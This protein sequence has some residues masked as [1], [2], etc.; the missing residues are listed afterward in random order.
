M[1][2]ATERVHGWKQRFDVDGFVSFGRI[3]DDARLR[4]LSERIDAICDGTVPVSAD[5]LRFHAGMEW[6]V[7]GEKRRDAIWQIMNLERHD[8]IVRSVCEAPVIREVIEELLESAAQLW[9]SQVI[10]KNA[11]HGGEIPWHQ[12]S[13]Y[14]GDERRLTCWLAIDAATPFNGCMRM[15][16]GSHLL[17]QRAF[18]PKAFA[19]M[20]V[21]LRET[22][23]VDEDTQVFV[24]VPAGCASF[25]HPLTLHASSANTTAERRRAIAI[26][27]QAL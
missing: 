21:D 13:S 6:E 15:I 22:D 12:D 9:S 1:Q 5:C 14:W 17:G 27:Y 7:D 4:E 16:P 8:D 25:H 19:G 26:T 3:L 23:E 2:T 24:P 10:M 20:P 18:T 11:F